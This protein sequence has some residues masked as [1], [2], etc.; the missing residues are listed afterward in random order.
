[1]TDFS[2]LL[3][4]FSLLQV[5][6]CIGSVLV[7]LL[8]CWFVLGIIQVVYHFC[9]FLGCVCWFVCSFWRLGLPL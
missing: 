5:P 7:D 6:V 3:F 2:L 4:L 9:L 8:L 1:M